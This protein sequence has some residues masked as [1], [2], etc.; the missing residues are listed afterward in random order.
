MRSSKK[1]VAE[2]RVA[3]YPEYPYGDSNTVQQSMKLREEFEEMI[4][5]SHFDHKFKKPFKLDTSKEAL[6]RNKSSEMLKRARSRQGNMLKQ[7]KSMSGLT[8]YKS[9]YQSHT[10]VVVAKKNRGSYVAEE[11]GGTHDLEQYHSTK[12]LLTR[13]QTEPTVNCNW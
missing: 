6:M 11:Y 8:F 10:V 7:S 13:L 3:Q 9:N 1:T 5:P 2:Q 12:L 4:E